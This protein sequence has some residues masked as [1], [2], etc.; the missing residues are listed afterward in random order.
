MEEARGSRLEEMNSLSSYSA[1][2]DGRRKFEEAGR[3]RGG[4]RGGYTVEMCRNRNES[5]T[6]VIQS[7]ILR[8]RLHGFEVGRER[9][10]GGTDGGE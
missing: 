7:P 6:T 4:I 2:G 10:E 9:V 3:A 8:S 1:G 5:S